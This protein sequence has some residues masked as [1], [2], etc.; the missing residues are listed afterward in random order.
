LHQLR[1]N[2]SAVAERVGFGGNFHAHSIRRGRAQEVEAKEGRPRAQQMLNHST[3]GLTK[4]YSTGSHGAYTV[5]IF[6]GERLGETTDP[7]LAI[8][9]VAQELHPPST[10]DVPQIRNEYLKNNPNVGKRK[11]MS[12]VLRVD[13]LQRKN[14][15][16]PLL[17]EVVTSST[18]GSTV[19]L[20]KCLKSQKM[21]HIIQILSNGRIGPHADNGSKSDKVN[22]ISMMPSQ[23]YP[24]YES[25]D[26]SFKVD[27][28]IERRRY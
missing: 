25:V 2:K 4:R 14:N 17:G 5:T 8:I 12:E 6:E 1:A 3:S 21:A 19:H 18:A 10:L 7:N 15:Y 11:A 16:N 27:T 24:V 28:D 22:N 26:R 23:S 9:S 20:S 13:K